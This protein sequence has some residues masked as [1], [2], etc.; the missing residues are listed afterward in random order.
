M[1]LEHIKKT[2]NSGTGVAMKKYLIV[3]LSELKSIDSIKEKD[4]PTHQSIEVKAQKRAYQKLKEI[5]QEIMTFSE[6]VKPKDPRDSFGI[7]DDDI[8]D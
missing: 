4:T 5:L 8:I 1:D 7:T 2:L 3:K 6:E